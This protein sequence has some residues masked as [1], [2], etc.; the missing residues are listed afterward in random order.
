MELRGLKVRVTDYSNQVHR[1]LASD[2]GVLINFKVQLYGI[3]TC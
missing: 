2:Y 1:K 3:A